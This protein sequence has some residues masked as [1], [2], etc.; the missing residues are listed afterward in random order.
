MDKKEIKIVYLGTPEISAKVLEK[1]IESGYN[2]VAVI[3][4][5]DKPVGRKNIITPTP[6]KVVAQKHSIPVFQPEKLRNDFSYLYDIKPDILLTM[7]YGQL[8]SDEILKIPS[9][10]P[11]N[12]HGS[13]L[14]KYR[15]ASP[16]QAALFNGDKETGVTLMEMVHEMDAGKL[17]YKDSFV[18]SEDDNYD[19]LCEKISESAF[20]CFDNGIQSVIDGTNLGEEQ[21]AEEVTFTKKIKPE[22]QIINFNNDAQKIVND[23]RALTTNPGAYFIYKNEKIKVQKAKAID[24]GLIFNPGEVISY[25]KKEFVVGTANGKLSIEI[26]Q[27]PGKKSMKINDFYNGNQNYFTVKEIIKW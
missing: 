2:I 14:P 17:F 23:I 13:L 21:N 20:R 4:Q 26:L 22:D 12:L 15:G 6:V 5:P 3:S 7:A 16:I 27:K 24:N 10:K 9:I 25:N 8:I 1:M 11:L 19:T 18:I